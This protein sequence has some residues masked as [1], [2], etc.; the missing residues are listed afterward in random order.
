MPRFS[1]NLNL[2]KPQSLLW[3]FWPKRVTLLKPLSHLIDEVQL[4]FYCDFCFKS[5]RISK[6]QLKSRLPLC[7][8]ITILD[9]D[10]STLWRLCVCVCPRTHKFMHA[11]VRM[12]MC[13]RVVYM[14]MCCEYI[15]I[16]TYMTVFMSC[17]DYMCGLVYIFV[18]DV[19]REYL[20]MK[21][22]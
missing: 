3:H 16:H 14:C 20:M 6:N 13:S 15:Y 17:S 19:E 5:G 7:S 11:S 22:L 4:F 1:L 10:Q 12:C 21:C 18:Q 9:L 2:F 8:K